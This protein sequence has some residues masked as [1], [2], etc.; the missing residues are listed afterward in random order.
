VPALAPVRSLRVA[1]SSAKT[2]VFSACGA[3][4][5]SMRGAR[6][7]S[8]ALKEIQRAT[9]KK[10]KKEKERRQALRPHAATTRCDHALRPRAATTLYLATEKAQEKVPLDEVR[11]LFLLHPAALARLAG[12]PLRALGV[13]LKQQRRSHGAVSHERRPNPRTQLASPPVQLSSHSA[14]K[15]HLDGR[16]VHIPGPQKAQQVQKVLI[17]RPVVA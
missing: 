9:E 6:Q 3:R 14:S 10:R 17:P 15:A 4:A 11:R 7:R 12:D 16:Q 1:R 13:H 8:K 5:R 2:C